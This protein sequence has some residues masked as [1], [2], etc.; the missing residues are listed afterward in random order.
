MKVKRVNKIEQKY[1]EC[2][3]TTY[4]QNFY[5]KSGNTYILIHNSP[6]VFFG[7]NPENGKFFVS[8]KAIFNKTPKLAYDYRTA[9]ELFGH[10]PGLLSKLKTC[11]D[12][13]PALGVDTIYQGD[14]LFTNDK[15]IENIN[16]TSYITF[17]PNT[18]TYAIPDDDSPLANKVRKAKLG[19]VVHTEY[20]GKSLEELTAK[21]NIDVSRHFNDPNVWLQDAYFRDESGTVNFSKPELDKINYLLDEA[22]RVNK[23]IKDDIF[24]KLKSF[25]LYELFRIFHNQ[26]IKG[27]KALQSVS[28]YFT[29]FITFI[30]QRYGEQRANLKSDDAKQKRQEQINN[31]VHFLNKYKREI[32]GLFYLYLIFIR[33]KEIFVTKFGEI[34]NI[35]TFLR[36]ADGYKV[37]SPEG[38]CVIDNE[39]NILKLV[40]RLEFS[41]ANFTLEKNW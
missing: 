24:K 25:G 18:I 13:L 28:Q 14:L 39:G 5:V 12:Y 36:S 20:S 26:N 32:I 40:D 1:P 2:D 22:E 16:G 8:T 35:D 33:L 31:A 9:D 17:T 15:K 4:N 7:I 41:R 34:K 19:I 38:F 23:Y 37:T 21:F 11:L 30:E 29:D 6:A 3:I 10:A 27:A